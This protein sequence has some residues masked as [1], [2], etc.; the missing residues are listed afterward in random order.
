MNPTQIIIDAVKDRLEGFDGQFKS[1]LLQ[2]V[3]DVN[4]C[5]GTMQNINNETEEFPIDSTEVSKLQNLFI[6]KIIKAYEKAKEKENLIVDKVI[7][8]ID[9]EHDELHLYIKEQNLEELFKLL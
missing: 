7:L 8:K 2:F 5:I 3:P 4:E 1:V 9:L 6:S